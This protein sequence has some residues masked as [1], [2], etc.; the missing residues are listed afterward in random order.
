MT[1]FQIRN[2]DLHMHSIF[3]DG[4][5]TLPEMISGVRAAGIDVFSLTDHDCL[6]G[7]RKMQEILQPGDPLFINGVELSCEDESGKY[8]ILGYGYHPGKL[9][10]QQTVEYT[11]ALR[12]EKAQNRMQY[13]ES[14]GFCFTDAEKEKLFSLKNPGKPHFAQLL[15]QKGYLPDKTAAFAAVSGYHGREEKLTP[16]A[17]ITAILGSDGIPVLAH[18][19]LADGSRK[20]TSEEIRSRVVKLKDMGLMGLECFY[21][22]FTGQQRETM[23]HLAKAYDLLITAGSDYHGKN[24]PVRLG[25]TNAEDCRCM[26]HFFHEV[27]LS[28]VSHRQTH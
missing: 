27:Y 23:L 11:H 28:A 12:R 15:M 21:S 1:D 10:L 3:S 2:P 9:A 4:T 19:I 17:A 22:G 24:K 8:H 20:L 14:R 16:Q 25:Q 13:L 26:E 18:G 7:C 6:D 5:D